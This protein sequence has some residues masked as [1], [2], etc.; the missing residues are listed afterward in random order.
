MRRLLTTAVL[1][2]LVL[3]V[4]T[5]VIYPFTIAGLAQAFFG[6]QANG[7]LVTNAK[8]QVVGS[9]E[10]GQLFTKPQYFHGRA[11]A[12]V[13]ATSPHG[14]AA[15]ASA[16]TNLG[17][18]S[19]RLLTTT[20][21]LAAQIRKEDGLPANYPLPADAVSTSASGLDPNISPAY[22]ALQVPRVARARGLSQ[23][24]V[25]ALV[26]EYTSGRDLGVFGEPRVNVLKLNL[27]LDRLK[28]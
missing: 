11:S 25:Q 6:D 1:M 16:G 12:A 15:D 21:A 24:T 26:Q 19:T 22:A 9:S 3:T 23:A 18:T 20:V 5:G 8:G 28:K 13:S 17:P 7:S 4:L 14:Y 10:I 2:T 27:A